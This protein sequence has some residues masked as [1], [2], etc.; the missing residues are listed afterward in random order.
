MPSDSGSAAGRT[1][2]KLIAFPRRS[3]VQR[4]AAELEFLPGALEIIETPASRVGRLMMGVIVLLLM[5]AVTWA[6][7]GEV[8]I[9]G[10]ANG[11]LIPAGQVR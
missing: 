7:I 10:V 3:L 2:A 4:R 5:V 6:S 1:A 11:R 8:D 9:I